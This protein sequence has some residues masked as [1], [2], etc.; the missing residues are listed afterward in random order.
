MT[1]LFGGPVPLPAQTA[2]EGGYWMLAVAAII[3]VAIV[4]AVALVR[5]IFPAQD[6]SAAEETPIAQRRKA[7]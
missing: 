7:A 2:S 1:F 5:G 4:V 3:A 6:K